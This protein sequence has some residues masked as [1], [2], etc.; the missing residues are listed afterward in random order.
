MLLPLGIGHPRRTADPHARERGIGPQAVEFVLILFAQVVE[1][2]TK[3]SKFL[4]TSIDPSVALFLLINLFL[5]GRH[6]LIHHTG[7]VCREERP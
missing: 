3:L 4:L 2:L 6:D 1:A 7:K 5:N